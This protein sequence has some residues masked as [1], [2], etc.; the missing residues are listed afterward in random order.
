MVCPEKREL[1]T[2]YASSDLSRPLAAELESH[3]RDCP[4]C[5]A[6]LAA[7]RDLEEMLSKSPLLPVRPG[8][9]ED[10]MRA[11]HRLEREEF[12]SKMVE[13][14]RGRGKLDLRKD[15]LPV[16]ILA[17]AAIFV[18]I[19]LSFL[20]PPILDY[21]SEVYMVV[22]AGPLSHMAVPPA[23][24]GATLDLISVVLLFS[25][26]FALYMV[27]GRA[28]PVRIRWRDVLPF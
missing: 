17:A 11:V 12:Q 16:G 6:E 3:V 27:S 9:V 20:I 26:L 22:T 7:A 2:R 19:G 25:F 15:I 1:I 28:N 13:I 18:S 21:L 10:I 8:L 23:G 5:R 14:V 4:S 24:E